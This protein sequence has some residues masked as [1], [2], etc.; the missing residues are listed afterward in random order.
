MVVVCQRGAVDISHSLKPAPILIRRDLL[1]DE[2]TKRKL[3]SLLMKSDLTLC[4]EAVW[5][6]LGKRFF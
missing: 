2:S 4:V 1:V 3:E 6:P 5:V